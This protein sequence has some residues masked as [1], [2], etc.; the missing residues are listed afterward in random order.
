MENYHAASAF[1]VIYEE[2]NNILSGLTD[3]QKK[4]I[5]E[6][7]VQM[8]MAT[9]MAQH[10]DLLGKFK[11]KLAGNGFDPK[12]R[13]DRLMMMQIA[14]K[15]ADI[16]NPCRPPALCNIWANRVM[17]EFYRQ[18]DEE[19]KHSMSV[20]AFMDRTKPAEAKC[21]IGFIDFIVGPLFEVWANFLPDMTKTLEYLEQNRLHWKNKYVQF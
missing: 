15:C 16:S 9:D 17:E 7:A 20:S 10:F 5:R 11:S 1:T 19:R 21:Q 8:V 18:G 2:Q 13:K 4:D 3:A 14:I 6:T 12:D